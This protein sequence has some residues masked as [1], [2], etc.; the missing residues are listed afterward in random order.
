M[1]RF[2]AGRLWWLAKWLSDI[3]GEKDVDPEEGP[4]GEPSDPLDFTELHEK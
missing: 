4:E 1:R 3:A 2:D